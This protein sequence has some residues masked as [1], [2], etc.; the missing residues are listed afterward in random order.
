MRRGPP[1]LKLNY[2]RQQKRFASSRAASGVPKF[3][4]FSILSTAA[5]VAGVTAYA[6]YDASFREKVEKNVPYSEMFFKKVLNK[7]EISSLVDLPGIHA[8]P[9]IPKKAIED[10]KKSSTKLLEEKT[11]KPTDQDKTPVIIANAVEPP[12]KRAHNPYIGSD[13]A[14]TKNEGLKKML[15][16]K[17]AKAENGVREATGAKLKT[18]RAI[19]HHIQTLREAIE[20]P[21]S[22]GDWDRVTEAHV[23]AQK[24][25]LIDSRTEKE[26]RLLVAE[27]SAEANLGAQGET[28]MFNPLVSLSKE[29]VK[30]LNSQLE[31]ACAM[32]REVES[33]KIFMRDYEKLVKEGRN[34]FALEIRA[35]LPDF[36]W[37]EGAKMKK[38]QLNALLTHAHLRVDQLSRQLLEQK[39]REDETIRKA[40]EKKREKFE[41][42]VATDTAVTQQ[43]VKLDNAKLDEELK[44]R[45]AEAEQTY[46]ERL[47]QVVKTQKQLYDIEHARDVEKAVNAERDTYKAQITRALAQLEGVEVAL[48]SHVAMDVENR[49]SKQV[50]LAVQ[51]LVN[52]IEYGNRAS[53]C[54]EGRRAP[55]EPQMKML[56]KCGSHDGFLKT[57]DELMNKITKTKGEYARGDLNTRFDKVY[58]IGRRVAWVDENGGGLMAHLFSWLR[59]AVSF[60]LNEA[61]SR[62]D[63]IVP[64]SQ[65][66][67]SLLNRAKAYW[68]AGDVFNAIRVLQLTTGATK[69]VSKDFID[70]ARRHEE[71]KFMARLLLAH[72]ALMSVRST[73]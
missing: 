30:Q 55:L 9:S 3:L 56:M 42:Q 21:E 24:M 68:Q 26:A 37:E 15:V 32:A 28:T 16:A 43:Q 54:M 25:K 1:C 38:A 14:E 47:E 41:A 36:D 73:Y 61:Y 59:S 39:L 53:C 44:K 29:T 17:I 72:S 11:V 31:K 57:I 2:S 48:K 5:G 63:K 18:I 34:R 70:D 40:V 50:W 22:S 52:T 62:E 64:S 13:Q 10:Q 35:V 49:R 67:F 20:A 27:L 46:K 23:E 19:E 8:V 58:R 45:L 6:T 66:N 7:H 65:S 60:S 4:G 12:A 71:A 33:E 69:R 51:N